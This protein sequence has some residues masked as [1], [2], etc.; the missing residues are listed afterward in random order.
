[1]N[2]PK[3]HNLYMFDE[4]LHHRLNTYKTI[5]FKVKSAIINTSPNMGSTRI[6]LPFST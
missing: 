5:M 4:M 3:H 6:F 1:M 2:F